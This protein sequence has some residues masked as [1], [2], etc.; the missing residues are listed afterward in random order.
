MLKLNKILTLFIV[1][2]IVFG[3]GGRLLEPFGIPPLRYVFFAAAIGLLFLNLLTLYAKASG[4][5]ILIFLVIIALP[6]WGCFIGSASG[7]NLEAILFDVQPYFYILIILYLCFL[8]NELRMFSVNTFVKTVKFY[9]VF[10][11]TLYILYILLLK[12]GM[13]NFISIYHTLSLTSE[14]FFRPS[15]AF[16][17]KSFFF[18]GIGAIFFFCERKYFQFLLVMCA[19][20]LTESRGVF[21]F[22]IIAIMLVS[23]KINNVFKNVTLIVLAVIVG[24]ALLIV[25]GGRAGDSDSVRLNDF[26]FI[27][28]QLGGA[29]IFVG[30][31]FGAEIS[32]RNRIEMVP[33]E[34]FYKTGIIGLLI[35]L[36][37]IIIVSSSQLL[38][39][40]TMTGLK[41]TCALLFAAGVSITNPFLYT[42]MGIFV[43]AM[44]VNI[45]ILNTEHH[46]SKMHELR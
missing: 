37:P 19:I 33:L 30:V 2:E 24:M 1:I 23:L 18:L 10:A 5:T 29:K 41:I 7:N 44:A 12:T 45:H 20:F 40:N 35:S 46:K 3:G 43:L 36:V 11:A 16:F 39:V 17:A 42:P 4:S 27:L 13:I 6:L 26:N 15:G 34:I 21:L 32:G 25:V 38:K 9:S 31:G 28:Q 14:F 22:S 8:P